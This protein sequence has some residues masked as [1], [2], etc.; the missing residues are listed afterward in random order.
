MGR[1]VQTQSAGDYFTDIF[2][3]LQIF[4]VLI[5]L[6][7][8]CLAVV[9]VWLCPPRDMMVMVEDPDP[10]HKDGVTVPF[11]LGTTWTGVYP[12]NCHMNKCLPWTIV[13]RVVVG[14]Y[15]HFPNLTIL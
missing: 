3:L 14:L 6:C 10:D 2:V 8:V 12:G 13:T 15:D 7:P 4:S 9:Y 1:R 11:I 5:V